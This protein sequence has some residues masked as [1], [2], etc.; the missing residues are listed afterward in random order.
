MAEPPSLFMFKE[1]LNSV[2][3]L[4]INSSS[5]R[6]YETFRTFAPKYG[7]NG[8]CLCIAKENN[9][10]MKLTSLEELE[11]MTLGPIFAREINLNNDI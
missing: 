7:V 11:D 8:P 6:T 9:K 1:V 5:L 2:I 4:K 3:R 10:S